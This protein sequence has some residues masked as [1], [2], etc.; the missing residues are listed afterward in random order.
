MLSGNIMNIWT[1]A[2]QLTIAIHEHYDEMAEQK[3]APFTEG[4]LN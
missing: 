3:A 1:K 2:T 4:G